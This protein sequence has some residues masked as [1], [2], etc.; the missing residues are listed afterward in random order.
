MF[1][2]F[3]KCWNVLKD[4]EGNLI[5]FKLCFKIALTLFEHFR[6]CLIVLEALKHIVQHFSYTR[7][8]TGFGVGT[9][10]CQH[11]ATWPNNCW[12]RLI[13]L[14][15]V[16]H[17]QKWVLF[18][19]NSRKWR[20]DKMTSHYHQ[21]SFWRWIFFDIKARLD[22]N[23]L[24]SSWIS[25]IPD[26]QHVSNF[27]LYDKFLH[28]KRCKIKK[29]ILRDGRNWIDSSSYRVFRFREDNWSHR[30]HVN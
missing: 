9:T 14:N 15:K 10:S 3:Q 19:R 2:S 24:T 11:F 22:D 18:L 21:S 1:A 12:K 29:T 27:K 28:L 25:A 8:R 7:M 26:S 13:S 20:L 17:V 6:K 5:L 16:L 23:S 30:R 4:I